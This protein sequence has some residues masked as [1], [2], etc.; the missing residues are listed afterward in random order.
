MFEN[1]I[2]Y[3]ELKWME[4]LAAQFYTGMDKF[5]ITPDLVNFKLERFVDLRTQLI[6]ENDKTFK[7]M[8]IGS[9]KTNI[10]ID[11]PD[12]L[13]NI[14]INKLPSYIGKPWSEI[15]DID[16]KINF[17][18]C[19]NFLVDNKCAPWV[20]DKLELKEISGGQETPYFSSTDLL[21]VDKICAKCD[22]F[23]E[24]TS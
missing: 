4:G 11:G 10:C 18:N 23:M 1:F 7:L 19:E 15:I 8:L 13:I 6:P 21:E 20:V 12:N 24:K 14:L 22:K 17:L 9:S 3:P 5:Q 2:H 16:L